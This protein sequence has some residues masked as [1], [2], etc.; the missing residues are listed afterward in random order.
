[1]EP[2]LEIAYVEAIDDCLSHYRHQSRATK[3][4]QMTVTLGLMQ[5]GRGIG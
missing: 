2:L 5:K 1:M 4:T 3:P